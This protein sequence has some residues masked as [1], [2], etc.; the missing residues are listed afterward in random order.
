MLSIMGWSVKVRSG[1]ADRL[2]TVEG[3]LT[4]GRGVDG[5]GGLPEDRK[6]SRRHARFL[7]G[8][9]GALLIEDLSSANGTEVNGVALEP[10]AP[11]ELRPGDV[12]VAGNSVLEVAERIDAV[13]PRAAAPVAPTPGPEPASAEPATPVEQ[14]GSP[15]SVR[16]PSAPVETGTITGEVLHAGGRVVVGAGGV[17]IGADPACE[18]VVE[19]RTVAGRHA[20]IRER[21]GR[22]YLADLGAGSG[23]LLNGELLQGESR[24]LTSGDSIEVGGEP[25][26]YVAGERTRLGAA[27]APTAGAPTVHLGSGALTIGRDPANDVV[28]DDPNVS[29][30]HAEV[31]PL[32]GAS[33]VRDLGSRNGTRVD[34]E[35]VSGRV[36]IR[37]GAEIGIGPFRLVFDGSRFV[38][39]DDRGAMRL[40]GEEVSMQIRDKLILN[41]ASIAVEPGEF[42][43]VIGESGSGKTTLVKALAG[44]TD[45]TGGRVLVSGE[46]VQ[47][48]LTDIG[49]VPQDE[50]VH[51][52]L[53]VFEGLR[54]AAWLRLPKDSTGADIDAAVDRV[55]DELDLGPHAETRIGSLSGGQRKRVG[56]GTELVN[57]PS[58]LFLDEPTTG[59]DPGLET[60][61]MEIFRELAEPGRRSVTVVTHATKNLDL[62]DKV[63]V[64]GQGGELCFFGPPQEAKEFFATPTFDGI[65]SAL[66]RRPAPEWRREFEAERGDALPTLEEPVAAPAAPRPARPRPDVG[67]Q[68]TLLARRYLTLMVR[69]RRNLA[70]LL[71]QVPLIALG[72]ALL[73][74]SDVLR[75][76]ADTNN[77]ALLLF[78]VV[79]SMIWLGA[80]DAAREIIKERPLMER[81]R[82]I[83]VRLS[84]YLGSKSIVLFGLV[85][86]Q[87]ALLGAVTFGL[88][89]LYESPPTYLALFVVLAVTGFVA[90]A[91]GL[92]ISSLVSSEDQAA[93][94]IPLALI[95]QLLFGGAIVAVEE[96]S[97]AMQQ[98]SKLVFSRWSFAD[99][100][101]AIDMGERISQSTSSVPSRYPPDF[102]E[103]PLLRGIGIVAA[104]MFAFLAL[105]YVTLEINR[106]QG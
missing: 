38:R 1:D 102:F 56:V 87:A 72:I 73:F 24:W 91:M 106:R 71:G 36:V 82:A 100:G 80:I 99:V 11:R 53:T 67:R 47:S 101:A 50:I 37:P 52:G 89:P 79:T 96:M 54:Y 4:I 95:P 51:R 6:V 16:P 97:G 43:V 27:A 74:K 9:D 7:L 18:V 64:M 32:E 40:R 63:C 86:V 61:L 59:L 103:L 85:M 66:D 98:L 12:I 17:T 94:F 104:F 83:G 21:D 20:A 34:G 30:F 44:V 65:Y 69:D 77:A 88:R 28:L 22:H 75:G 19:A 58:L 78:L 55:L 46:P 8:T 29:R 35:F 60:R 23:T 68:S 48:R 84:A 76:S 45:P 41:R 15:S 42:V 39:R 105:T 5:A 62:P 13:T 70:I 3:E 25:L 90:V 49:Y 92:W 93:S 14:V 31:R 26:R 10:G 2:V 57:R 81:E 33:E